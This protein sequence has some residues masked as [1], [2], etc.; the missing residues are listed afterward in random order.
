MRAKVLLYALLPVIIFMSCKKDTKIETHPSNTQ[1]TFH[2]NA[3]MNDY[4]LNLNGP[5]TLTNQNGDSLNVTKFNYYITNIRLT[6]MDGSV[7]SE[8]ESYHLIEHAFSPTTSFTM[9]NLPEGTYNKIEFLVGVDSAHN[10]SGSQVGDLD[11]GRAM[12]WDWNTG[13]I[14]LKLEGKYKSASTPVASDYAIH[15]GGYSLPWN[16]I[17]QISLP[18][19]EVKI[20]D[21]ANPSVFLN[22]VI[23]E[24]F[25]TPV[26][27]DLDTYSGVVGGKN[28]RTI[29]YNYA[30]M[31]SVSKVIN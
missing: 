21:A 1:V 4:P 16:C 15:I 31:F 26:T 23:D 3:F 11:P 17:R 19:P 12:F 13:Y 27:I 2:F 9:K 14:F 29:S 18:M 28:A 10:V 22:V 24:M 5:V 7:Y 30:D 20:A 6:N 8:P 25:K